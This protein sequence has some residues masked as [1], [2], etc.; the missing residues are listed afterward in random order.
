[1]RA[2]HTF[3]GATD[4]WLHRLL[5]WAPGQTDMIKTVALVLMVT[6]HTGLLLAGNNEV[7]RLLGRGCFPL[8]GLAWGMNLARHAEIRQSQLNSLWVWALVAQV[9]FMLI[10]Y[11]WYSGN[12]LFAFAVTGQV[13][14]W[15]SQ[16]SWYYTLPAAGLLV[17]WIPLS[18]ASYGM[19]GVGMLTASW[20]LCRAQHAQERLGYGVL[21]ALMVLLMNMHDVSESVAGLAI[22]LL[23]LMVCSSAGERVKR[24]WPRQ[25]FVMFYAVH[26]AVLGIVVSM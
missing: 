4:R 2:Q 24:F 3:P 25:F 8:F 23:T 17:A 14:R 18:T 26:L 7:M 10:G 15:V 1:M 21:W 11:P 20:L 12:I 13:L 19:A 5:T 16:P 9:S 22:A 6:D